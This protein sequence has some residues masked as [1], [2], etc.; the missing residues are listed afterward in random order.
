MT[1]G[2]LTA[3]QSVQIRKEELTREGEKEHEEMGCWVRDANAGRQGENPQLLQIRVL[4]DSFML[5]KK[6]DS[7]IVK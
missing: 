3:L 6:N 2:D 5:E 7:S 4:I 1:V